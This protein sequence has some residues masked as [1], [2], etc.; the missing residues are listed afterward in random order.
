MLVV[1]AKTQLDPAFSKGQL[2]YSYAMDIIVA[3]IR[4]DLM[5]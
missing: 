1:S 2:M 4:M 5:R 3:V